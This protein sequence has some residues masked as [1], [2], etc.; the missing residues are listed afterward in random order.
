MTPPANL[1]G[2][3]VL[4]A[5]GSVGRRVVEH[6]SRQGHDVV[7]GSRSPASAQQI[8]NGFP[9]AR[10][11]T[12]DLHDPAWTVP[13]DVTVVIDC[14]GTDRIE[15]A[16][17]V[18]R[19]GSAFIDISASTP[20]VR[21]LLDQHEGVQDLGQRV[22]VGCGLAPGIS[23]MLAH[24]LL[25][26]HRDRPVRIDL[27]I[28]LF[29][30]FGAQ[31]A[32]FTEGLIGTSFRDP[33]DGATV[34]NFSDPARTHLPAGFGTA[35]TARVNFADVEILAHGLA[36]VDMRLGFRQRGGTRLAAKLGRRVAT[37]LQSIL[38]RMQQTIRPDATRPWLCMASTEQHRAWA[39]GMGQANATATHVGLVVERLRSGQVPRG[40]IAAHEVAPLD[41]PSAAYLRSSGIAV[42]IAPPVDP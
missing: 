22:V 9:R 15:T 6:L 29:D 13:S 28:D 20:Y 26:G 7:V 4:G 23:T 37:T 36:G 27:V 2:P 25:T 16:L 33:H 34:E 41:D 14:T 19:S 38:E 40:V 31:A 39:T 18:C 30:A 42:A 35:T 8:A 10:A 1:V 11:L 21:K 3:L 32:T 12:V 5:T 17:R 24:R